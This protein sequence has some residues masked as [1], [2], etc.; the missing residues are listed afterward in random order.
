MKLV[1]LGSG[2]FALPTL[3][4]LAH[5]EHEIPLVITQP[6]KGAGRG[7]RMTRTP[8]AAEAE[9]Y[10]LTVEAVENVNDD[11]FVRR[12][13]EFKADA[14]VVIAFGQ[15]LGP[16]FRETAVGGYLNLHA[17]LLPK[18]RGAAPINWA[19]IRGETRTGV[20]VFRIVDRMDAGPILTTRWTDIKPEETTGELHDR[21][22]AIGV[23]AMK[24]AVALFE[25]NPCPAGEPQDDAL[26]TKAPKLS[27][28]D[29]RLDFA[30]PAAAIAAR[31]QGVT[32]WPG[33]QAVFEA[34]DGRW[35]EVVICRARPAE[36]RTK[37][38]IPPGQL[39][40]RRYIATGDGFLELLEVKP[41]SGRLMTWP[42]YVNGRNVQA[43]DEFTTPAAKEA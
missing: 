26:A 40:A 19:L 16:A 5:S 29:G 18:Y 3:R 39:D 37:A 34:S 25:G 36:P 20:T 2:A 42:E 6:A 8:V 28:A 17:S 4:W 27:K 10:G 43:G 35:E 41:S 22:A 14:G 38:T 30:A 31:I 13:A 9:S 33:A 24:G 23:D 11:A 15:K 1:F 12:V 32:P 7:R 21:L